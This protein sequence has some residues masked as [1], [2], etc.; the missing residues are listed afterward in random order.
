[1]KKI[2]AVV[3]LSVLLIANGFGITS[4]STVW[5]ASSDVR[6]ILNGQVLN[7][8][9]YSPYPNG[10]TVMIPLRESSI[11]L[12]YKVAYQKSSDTITLSGVKQKIEYKVGDDHIT[13]NDKEKRDF[14]DDV[15]FKKE[16]LYVPLSFF[17]SLGLLTAY[18]A[19]ANLAEIYTPEVIA[20]AIAGLLTTGQFQVLE[21]RFFS[22]ELKRSISGTGL[23]QNWEEL[24]V[25]AGNYHGV[26]A[27]ESNQKVDQF[28][29]QCVLSFA[30]ADASLEIILN[31]SG[32]IIDLREKLLLK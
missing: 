19:D 2:V 29:I 22:E 17:T 16:H 20:N 23:Q 6:V 13:I 30:Q 10:S 7:A 9:P 15:V 3:V 8:D 14:K 1:M 24:S 21:D 27:T 18:D 28:S 12:K 4:S 26:K 31:K 5:A 32:K 11:A 25:Q